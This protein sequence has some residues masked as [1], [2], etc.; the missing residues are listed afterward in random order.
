MADQALFAARTSARARAAI[1]AG[2]NVNAKDATGTPALLVALREDRP[3]VF[4]FLLSDGFADVNATDAE[5]RTAAMLVSTIELSDTYETIRDAIFE[6]GLQLDV[7]A[8]DNSGKS[9]LTYAIDALKFTDDDMVE[10]LIQSG[11]TITEQNVEDLTK[12]NPELLY[13]LEGRPI[14][15]EGILKS[16]LRASAQGLAEVSAMSGS[17]ARPGASN[18]ANP[19]AGDGSAA[20]PARLNRDVVGNVAAFLGLPKTKNGGKRRGSRRTTKRVTRRRTMRR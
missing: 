19:G 20:P 5:G 15:P 14:A 9:A 2:A 6:Y 3:R 8:E 17:L 11:A 18:A 1:A 16:K 4:K 7:N 10:F 12:R 13:L